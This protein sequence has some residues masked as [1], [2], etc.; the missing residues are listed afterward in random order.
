[1][2]SDDLDNVPLAHLLKK[3]NVPE[4]IDEI[5]VAPSVSA[6]SQESSSTEGVFFPTLSIAPASNVQPGSSVCS[7]PSVSLP[8]APDDAHVYV[9]DNVPSDVSTTS[10]GQTD[11]QSNENEVDPSNTAVCTDEVPTNADDSLVVPP[12][13]SEVPVALKPVKRKSQQNRCNKTTKIG[14]KKIPPNIPSVPIDGILF[15]HEENVQCWKFVVQRWLADEVNV[16]DKHQSCMSIMD[17]IERAGLAK[18]ILNVGPFY[19]QLIREFIINL[20]NEFS[21]P[22]NVVD[23]D[24][25][26]SSPSTDVLASVLSGGT[27]ST[28][29]V[30]GIFAVA[31]SIKYAIMHKIGIANWFPSSHASSVSTAL[32]T[33]LYQICNDNKVDTCAFIYNQQLR[34]VGLFR[35][36]VSIALPRFFSSLLLHLNGAVLTAS[37]APRPDPKTLSLSYRLFQGSHVPD[38]DHDVHPSCGSCIFDRSDWDESDEGFFVDRKLASC[39]VNSLTAESRA[40]SISINLLS[41][42]CLEVDSSHSSF[43]DFA[44]FTSRKENGFE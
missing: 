22:S 37:D 4:V 7:P 28:W 9:L 42:R 41:E 3:T 43:K 38:I 20:P 23:I 24:C 17:L 14:R 15:H 5:P 19:P 35:V 44:P 34:H 11:V 26:P 31:L 6:H 13:S 25:S 29:P 1:M 8:F 32:G 21:D 10:E 33:F 12:S 18:T 30:N 36:K 27:L 40:L 39:I 2:D 16:F